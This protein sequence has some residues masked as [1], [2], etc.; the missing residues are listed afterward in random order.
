MSTKVKKKILNHNH[1]GEGVPALEKYGAEAQNRTADTSL[2]RAVLCQL[3]YL[4][5]PISIKTGTRTVQKR[6][7]CVPGFYL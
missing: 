3:S 2:F 7:M 4:G 5:I 1:R 6:P